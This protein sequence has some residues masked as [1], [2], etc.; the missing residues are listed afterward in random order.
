MNLK[1]IDQNLIN[2]VVEKAKASPRKRTNLNFHTNYEDPINR[3]LKPNGAGNLCA[4]TQ[5]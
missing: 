5:A 4:A 1:V 3:L 2:S